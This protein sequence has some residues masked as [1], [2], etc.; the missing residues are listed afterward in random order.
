MFLC[1]DSWSKLEQFGL[2][3]VVIPSNKLSVGQSPWYLAPK[4]SFIFL[5]FTLFLR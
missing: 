2:S 4:P 3:N 5:G 1:L